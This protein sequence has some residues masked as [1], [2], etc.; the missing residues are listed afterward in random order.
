MKFVD[1]VLPLPLSDLF[2]YSIPES[3]VDK[4]FI[5]NRVIVSF[6]S[7]KYYTAIVFNIHEKPPT[8]YVVKPIESVIDSTPVINDQQ[9]KLWRWISFYYMCSIGEVYSAAIPAK[10]K[11]ES[12]AFL[13]PISNR[14]DI[15]SLS[16]QEQL[17]V[18]Y[19]QE[20]GSQKISNISKELNIKDVLPYAHSLV[21]K[22]LVDI[23]DY[24]VEKYK[25][26]YHTYIKLNN[27]IEDA[28]SIIGSAKKQFELYSIL[29]DITSAGKE[30]SF[31]KK[32]IN[33]RFGFSLSVLNALID[34]GVLLQYTEEVSRISLS[35]SISREAFQ[36]NKHQKEAFDSILNIF[37]EKNVCLLHGVTSSGKTE[38]YI[39]LIKEQLKKNKQVLYLVPEIALT[40]QLTLRL[41]AVFGDKLGVYHS[42]I[43]DNERAE[44]WTK[45]S[46]D[47]PF[48]IV[49]G[50]RSSIFLPYQHLGLVIVDE[51]HEV[52]Y[53][54]ME[55]APRYHARDTSIVMAHNYGAK[56]LLGSATPSIETYYNANIGK[57]GLVTISHRYDDIE[58]PTIELEN[59]KELKRKRI[60]KSLL[61][62]LMIDN[63]TEALNNKEQVI[64]FRNRR[65]FSPF[66][67]CKN[68]G[69]T[70]KCKNCD[71]SLTYHKFQ[72]ILKCHYCNS[73]Y[74]V[75]DECPVCVEKSV[76]Q[77]GM[78]TEMLEEEVSR[79]FPDATTARMDTDTTRG[80]DSYERIIESFEKKET[81]I[82]V[83]T[84][85]LS[86][87][88]D[89]ENVSIVGIIAADG[90]L[91]HPDFR[92][93]ER[94]F[95]LMMQSAGRA[96]RKKRQ[97]RVIVQAADPEV[98]LFKYL[99]SN[100]YISFYNKEL[101]ERKL[102][103]YPPYTRLISIVLRHRNEQIVNKGVE[104]FTSKLKLSLGSMVLGPNKPVISY[105]QKYH[106]RNILLKIDSNYSH[107]KVREII[108]S[109]EYQFK[110]IQEF[111]Y[112][113][114]YYDVDMV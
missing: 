38:I 64:L 46:S 103:N 6:G 55:P 84:Q 14:E 27:E 66:L 82:L 42:M 105:V 104:F 58:M 9:I 32:D 81:D 49:I 21:F 108:N 17:I 3:M 29:K 73:T 48:S 8:D 61:T 67:E 77:F 57:Y 100:D 30:V 54:Q 83:G 97:G 33:K 40:T 45:M 89:F 22:G 39:H 71:V 112:I 93:H 11:L 87:G 79:I 37:K 60:M 23:E 59:T 26:K 31:L 111:K 44:I 12:E 96:G 109:I 95:Q 76:E 92:S 47:N 51:E 35:S 13:V 98:S 99:Q 56:V 107:I 2:T 106:I 34:K 4:V 18:S 74:K 101:A 25:P 28:I 69:W 62:P 65:G 94:G 53:K 63:I 114:L 52:G 75:I 86:K 24:V 36:L 1:V 7:R 70:P 19:L 50:V 91:N 43:N 5:G 10:L 85:M 102:F 80:K 90:L 16:K 72:N 88:L 113:N 68:C 20:K 15:G 78:G 41:Q 110:N